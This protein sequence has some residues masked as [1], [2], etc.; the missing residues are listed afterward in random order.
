MRKIVYVILKGLPLT[1]FY[2]WGKRVYAPIDGEIVKVIDGIEERDPVN[3]CKDI[4][5]TIVVTKDFQE[6]EM[7]F[8]RIAGNSVIIKYGE[9]SYCLLAHMRKGSVRV[10][11]GQRIERNEVIGELG[12]SGNST[13]P[14]LHMQFMDS[15]NFNETKGI[16]F[17]IREY[18]LYQNG[19][20][21][22]K[23]NSI[24]TK[25]DIIKCE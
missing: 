10:K 14:H 11:E 21:I 7:G 3:I 18:F 25:E 2:G 6:R 23:N 24:P 15:L 5:N 16:P 20:W 9:K 1:D 13:M 17:V 19:T 22:K 12:H 4:R 8:E